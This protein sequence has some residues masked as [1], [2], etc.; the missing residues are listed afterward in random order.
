M[1]GNAS[2]HLSECTGAFL[3]DGK[4][5]DAFPNNI[6][7][8]YRYVNIVLHQIHFRTCVKY[9]SHLGLTKISRV[10]L[11]SLL[12]YQKYNMVTRLK[13]SVV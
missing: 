13:I 12:L 9:I 11:E 1:R 2:G 7:A 10:D 3:K 4:S 8:R 6:R 5:G